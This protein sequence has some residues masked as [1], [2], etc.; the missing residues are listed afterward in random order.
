MRVGLNDIWNLQ[1]IT[2]QEQSI[3]N[4]LPLQVLAS[5]RMPAVKSFAL[6]KQ[7][8]VIRKEMAALEAERVKL[9]E[10]LGVE[11]KDE[12]GNVTGH[13]I[14]PGSDAWQQFVAE[15]EELCE[16]SVEIPGEPLTLADLGETEISVVVL[17]A[18]GFL[19]TEESK[20]EKVVSIKR[21]RKAKAA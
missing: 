14:T 13:S 7:M 10:R 8:A 19:L 3:G 11:N 20:P 4:P 2:A 15:V 1:N 18:I 17:D 9:I 21:R 5:V 12:Q 6:G 16:A